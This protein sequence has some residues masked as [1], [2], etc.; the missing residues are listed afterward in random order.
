MAEVHKVFSLKHSL[1]WLQTLLFYK[2]LLLLCIKFHNFNYV[3]EPGGTG[4]EYAHRFLYL[5]QKL[6]CLQRW[7]KLHS[8]ATAN[9]KEVKSSTTIAWK[10][11]PRGPE[12]VSIETP[13]FRPKIYLECT[14][15]YE[16]C[17]TRLKVFGNLMKWGLKGRISIDADFGGSRS[18]EVFTFFRLVLAILWLTKQLWLFNSSK[19][20][21]RSISAFF[22]VCSFVGCHAGVSHHPPKIT[23][24]S[25]IQVEDGTSSALLICQNSTQ[26]K[27]I[28]N[29]EPEEWLELERESK[30]QGELLYLYSGMQF[31][32]AK[33][34]SFIER[35]HFE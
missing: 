30:S 6:H 18:W 27:K 29:L 9:V 33:K 26:L 15:K 32:S 19:N 10:Y 21:D 28:F 16:H 4:H 12:S 13:S 31:K 25:S 22:P 1:F 14:T 34:Q 5:T 35:I 20:H 17:E 11:I 24:N 8:M 23:I 3:P 7:A 2:Y